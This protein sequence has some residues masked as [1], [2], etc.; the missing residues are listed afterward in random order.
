MRLKNTVLIITGAANGLGAEYSRACV[1]EG[2]RVL[3]ADLDEV[4]ARQLAAEL[5]EGQ[6]DTVAVGMRVDVSD[7]EAAIRMAQTCVEQFGRIDVLVNNAGTYPHKDFVEITPADWRAV[8]AVNLDGVFNCCHAVL[9]TMKQQG[10]GKIINVATNLVF[11]GL[12]SMVHYVSAKAGLLGFTRSLAREV[13]EHGIT[14]NA[15]A[16]G[17]VIPPV[18]TL[19]ADSIERVEAI[20][21]HQCVKW[22]MRSEDLV[23]P[24]LFLCSHESDFISA[25][26]LT[27]DGGLTTH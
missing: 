21:H 20:L 23:G 10:A 14:V 11:I 9:S 1:R 7:P 12:A 26:V 8:M 25:Q 27:V 18:E 4:N 17:A 5:N 22:C 6:T 3:I 16:P 24:M 15:L 19:N 13:G 2:A